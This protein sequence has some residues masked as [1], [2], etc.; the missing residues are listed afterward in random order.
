MTVVLTISA[1][2]DLERIG[3]Y[4][5]ASNPVRAYEFIRELREKAQEIGQTPRAFSLV[6]RYEALGVRRRVYR[7][8][9]IFYRIE[10]D[11]IVILHI[12][13]GAQDYGSILFPEE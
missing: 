5:A 3:D 4:I 6:P 12:L 13:H 8:Y 1:L 10:E 7:D 11:R 9:L 2:E